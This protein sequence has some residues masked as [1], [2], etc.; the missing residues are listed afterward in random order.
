MDVAVA[1][2]F[3]FASQIANLRWL[4]SKSEYEDLKKGKKGSYMAK[5]GWKANKLNCCSVREDL[6][7]FP[8]CRAILT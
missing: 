2:I 7:V 1:G 8:T 6:H 4:V 3:L 5:L